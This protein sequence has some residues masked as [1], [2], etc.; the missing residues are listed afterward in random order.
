MFCPRWLQV[1]EKRLDCN[2][3]S[4]SVVN[5][6]M[7]A[8]IFIFFFPSAL[9]GYFGS[10]GANFI[11]TA[12]YELSSLIT[13]PAAANKS[14]PF[15]H[16]ISFCWHFV[17]S[18]LRLQVQ[19]NSPAIT[20][21]TTNDSNQLDSSHFVWEPQLMAMVWVT[22]HKT[23]WGGEETIFGVFFNSLVLLV[24]KKLAILRWYFWNNSTYTSDLCC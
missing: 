6:K 11:I 2:K 20:Q 19:I 7:S 12:S 8:Y 5:G 17:Y 13:G 22:I 23:R 24:I 3:K 4:G 18:V 10:L 16:L 9:F 1:V 15:R 21:M 14:C